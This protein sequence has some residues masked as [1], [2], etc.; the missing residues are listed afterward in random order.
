MHAK[1]NMEVAAGIDPNNVF[2]CGF[3]QG[4]ALILVSVKKLGR[5]AVFRRWVP[6]NS[7]MIENSK[8]MQGRHLDLHLLCGLGE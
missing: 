2:V 8:K 4:G 3:S 6:L 7:L 5:G 1:I